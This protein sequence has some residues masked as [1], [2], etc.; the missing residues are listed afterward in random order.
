MVRIGASAANRAART[1][2]RRSSGHGRPP[3]HR[4]RDPPARPGGPARRGA[5]P[6]PGPASDRG[7]QPAGAPGPRPPGWCQPPEGHEGRL[8]ARRAATAAG[9]RAAS[10]SA[11]APCTIAARR[12]GPASRSATGAPEFGPAPVTAHPPAWCAA[13]SGRRPLAAPR[14]RLPPAL[15]H[16]RPG[17]I[18]LGWV[19]LVWP[20]VATATPA[21]A[22]PGTRNQAPG[23]GA[24]TASSSSESDHR[25]PRSSRPGS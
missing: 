8:P 23:C 2:P 11:G 9:R 20:L 6:L 14:H 1:G 4:H 3:R 25:C 12:S 13:P 5:P 21:T 15:P 10:A 22:P 17:R 19:R 7:R 24:A 18:E 16:A